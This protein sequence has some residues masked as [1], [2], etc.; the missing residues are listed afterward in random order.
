[1]I[2]AAAVVDADELPALWKALGYISS[3]AQGISGTERSDTRV[4]FR[5]RSGLTVAFEQ[6]GIA[7]RFLLSYAARAGRSEVVRSLQS[8]QLATLRD[9]LELTL[10]DLKRQGAQIGPVSDTK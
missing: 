4:T 9:L 6:S 8:D 3:T 10:Y 1:M 2:A 7:Q 5:T